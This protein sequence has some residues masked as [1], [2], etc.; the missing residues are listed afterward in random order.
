MQ[1]LNDIVISTLCDTAL[2]SKRIEVIVPELVDHAQK[3]SESYDGR[4]ETLKNEQRGV[5][6][7]LKKLWQQISVSEITLD[8]TL[9]KFIKELQAKN[10]NH[11]RAIRRLEQQQAFPVRNL[12]RN[13]CREFAAAVRKLLKENKDPKFTRVYL[14]QV[15]TRV[16]VGKSKIKM[17]G[18]KAALAEQ[19]IAFDSTKLLVPTFDLKWCPGEDSNLHILANTST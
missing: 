6:N 17:R 5:K 19:P 3:R 1:K 9:Q 12:T 15:I 14:A 2:S 8:A 16:D 11:S 7:Q 10:E 18:P 13:D 4:V